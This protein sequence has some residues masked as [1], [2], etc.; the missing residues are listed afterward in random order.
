MNRFTFTDPFLFLYSYCYALPIRLFAYFARWR[1]R[2]IARRRTINR[3]ARELARYALRV[4]FLTE[5]LLQLQQEKADLRTAIEL[6][7]LQLEGAF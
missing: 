7:T 2:A 5:E 1:W 6:Q 4:E 3:Q